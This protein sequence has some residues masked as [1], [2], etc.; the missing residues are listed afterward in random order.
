MKLPGDSASDRRDV[1]HAVAGR[2]GAAASAKPDHAETGIRDCARGG[3][4][5]VEI[6]GLANRHA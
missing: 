2:Y 6:N 1:D 3:I 4:L 5:L